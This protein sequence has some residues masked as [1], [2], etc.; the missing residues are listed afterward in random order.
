MYRIGDIVHFELADE[1][2][3]PGLLPDVVPVNEA[4]GVVDGLLRAFRSQAQEILTGS[5]PNVT[6]ADFDAAR[7][8]SERALSL[9]GLA[10]TLNA[11]AEPPI[12]H[13]Q[14][15]EIIRGNF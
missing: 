10:H 12:P 15:V 1:T 3:A 14:V 9:R 7:T 11:H 4:A 5:R 2:T 8:A 6:A 13:G